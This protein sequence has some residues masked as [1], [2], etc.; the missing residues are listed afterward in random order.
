MKQ[1]SATDPKLRAYSKSLGAII[2]RKL[3]EEEGPVHRY[4]PKNP[5]EPKVPP[6]F[7]MYGV[8]E[9]LFFSLVSR[10]GSSSFSCSSIAIQSVPVLGAGNSTGTT[11][12]MR[13]WLAS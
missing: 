7:F 5:P 6:N 1:H 8:S 12:A 10:G 3:T 11:S 4:H 9:I 2:Q 13:N